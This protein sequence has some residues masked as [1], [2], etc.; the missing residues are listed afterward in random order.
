MSVSNLDCKPEAVKQP[1]W[2]ILTAG[3]SWDSAEEACWKNGKGIR[4][5]DGKLVL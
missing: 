4:G 2:L 5:T 1:T 3:C